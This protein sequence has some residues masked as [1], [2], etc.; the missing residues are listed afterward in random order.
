V[1]LLVPLWLVNMQR[2]QVVL[3]LQVQE[4]AMLVVLLVVLLLELPEVVVVLLA[5][6]VAFVVVETGSW[7]LLLAQLLELQLV[8][9]GP[10]LVDSLVDSLFDDF[11]AAVLV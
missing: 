1:L 10:W 11:I 4:L 2:Q 7:L 8:V 9:Q 6:L 3:W 5:T